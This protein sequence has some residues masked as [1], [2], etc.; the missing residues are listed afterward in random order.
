[1]LSLAGSSACKACASVKHCNSFLNMSASLEESYMA[2][3]HAGA[4]DLQAMFQHA[5]YT[6]DLMFSHV[7]HLQLGEGQETAAVSDAQS[8][9]DGA[10]QEL[11]PQ[12]LRL[13]RWVPAVHLV[14][15]LLSVPTVSVMI[16]DATL[17]A[18]PA[19]MRLCMAHV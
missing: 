15:V 18:L 8:L 14:H 7:V 5:L 10:R 19:V 6:C 4:F 16:S 9:A 1:M 12:A 13:G 17:F 3:N 2:G 11:P